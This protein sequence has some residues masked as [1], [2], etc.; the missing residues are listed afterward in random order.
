MKLFGRRKN[1]KRLG[2]GLGGGGAKGSVHLGA[3]RAFEEEGIRFD[4]V[5]GTSIGSFIGALYAH[6][7][8]AGEIEAIL[9]G[10]D[11][12]D[13]KSFLMA[14]ISG[15]GIDGILAKSTGNMEFEDLK[16]PY[17][18][19]AVDLASGEK[20]VFTDGVLSKCMGA[21]CAIPPY[22]KAVEYLGRRFVDGAYADVIPCDVAKELGAD[23]VIGIDLT[24]NR[25][26]SARSKKTL[27]EMYPNN[28]VRVCDP[29]AEGYAACDYML[30]PDL[31][32]FGATNVGAM[33]EMFDIGYFFAKEHMAEIKTALKKA[34]FYSEN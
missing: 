34:G 20:V 25:R 10:S 1:E 23:F 22:F 15:V 5:A 13:V 28:G 6:G 19:V 32:G 29:S 16:I 31:K 9:I 26:S 24:G 27:D 4:V 21:S 14:R 8:T 7:Y 11:L 3:L 33:G 12:D 30:A 2:L 17:A 18:A